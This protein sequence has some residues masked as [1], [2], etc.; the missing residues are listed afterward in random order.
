MN[1]IFAFNPELSTSEIVKAGFKLGNKKWLLTFGLII[2][3]G[4]IAEI[5][6][7]LMC[8][9]GILVTAS[10]AYLPAYFIYKESVGFDENNDNEAYGMSYE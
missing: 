3:S 9:V 5:I 4:L 10:F 8:C 6:G 2:I 7:L 1:V